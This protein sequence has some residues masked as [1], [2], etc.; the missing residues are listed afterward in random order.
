VFTV[1]G[2]VDTSF[3]AFSA[4]MAVGDTTFG[5]VVEPGVAFK[6]GILT[7]SAS[8]EI[9]IDSTLG[10]S[11]GTFSAGGTKEVAMG[12]YAGRFN[13]IDTPPAFNIVVNGGQVISQENGTNPRSGL[14][15]VSATP[16]IVDS[17][18]TYIA[19]PTVTIQQAVDGPPGF[20]YSSKITVTTADASPAA[21]DTLAWSTQVEGYRIESLAWGGANALN[22]AVGF[23]VKAN[24]TGTYSA[25]VRASDKTCY[26]FNFTIN[27]SGTWEYKTKVIPG[28]TVGTWD[29]TTGSGLEL[30]VCMMA[31]SSRVQTADTWT[32]TPANHAYGATGTINGA[33][34]TS[35]YMN[36]TGVSIVLG[37][38]PVPAA[39][40]SLMVR[41]FDME[42]LSCQRY[43]RTWSL[44][45]TFTAQGPSEIFRRSWSSLPSMRTS[46]P[47]ITLGTPAVSTNVALVSL[48]KFTN[49]DNNLNLQATA[50]GLCRWVG[51][52]VEDA[53]L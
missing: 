36:V 42:M 9:T 25:V 19:G 5:F 31:G 37:N 29:I 52:V 40:S 43:F 30:I 7:Y 50:A 34:A 53:R 48:S 39:L 46:T 32:V 51:G 45:Q 8:N 33:A 13:N 47:T 17:V 24:R 3:N 4:S 16:Y 20:K 44:E 22:V 38:T 23:W 6:S 49:N 18:Y 35:D 14:T 15:N 21:L 28:P 11:K 1:T 10:E 41:P 26:P 12:L 2:A 27:A